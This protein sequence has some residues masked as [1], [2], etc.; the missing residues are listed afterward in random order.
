VKLACP[1]ARYQS[2][3]KQ[4]DAALLGYRKA[5]L[6]GVAEV[7][8]A[9]GSL[10]R[11]DS[12]IQSLQVADE[13]ARQQVVRQAR[14]VQLGLSSEFDGLET[15]RAALSAQADLI[16]AQGARVLAF[17]SL[18]RAVGGAPLPAEPEGDAQ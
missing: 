6:Q 17:A 14:Q 16:G 12:S 18:Y 11:Q 5:V 2:D 3:D 10:A 7:E 13:A 4:L 1:R 8:G 9:L 15:Q